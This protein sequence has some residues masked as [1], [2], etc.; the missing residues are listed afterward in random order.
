MINFYYHNI[1]PDKN[2]EGDCVT[3]AIAIASGI[4]YNAV[5]KLL[6]VTAEENGCDELCLYC[7]RILLE[8]TLG[9]KAMFPKELKRVGE[10]AKDYPNNA[11][12]VRIDGHLTSCM[13]GVCIDIWDCT[14]E[15]ADCFW[16]VQ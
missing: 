8:K 2:I 1:N 4:P 10:I 13:Y 15:E 6:Q 14:E 11:I 5:K 3:R 16:I 9:Y 7:Y 12:I